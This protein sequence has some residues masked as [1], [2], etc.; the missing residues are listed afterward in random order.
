[1]AHGHFSNKKMDSYMSMIVLLTHSEGREN[2]QYDLLM[3]FQS[4]GILKVNK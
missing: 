1:M 3:S 2:D 4:F